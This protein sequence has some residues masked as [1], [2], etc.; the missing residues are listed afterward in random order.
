MRQGQPSNTEVYQKPRF[1]LYASSEI[2]TMV[3]KHWYSNQRQHLSNIP[4]EL[5]IL[6]DQKQTQMFGK[7]L[8]RNACNVLI[9]HRFHLE[10]W[11]LF[12]KQQKHLRL[13]NTIN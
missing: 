7:S 2:K 12:L 11:S 4:V 5:L 3:S 6:S 1:Q 10:H 8:R 9:D 13:V